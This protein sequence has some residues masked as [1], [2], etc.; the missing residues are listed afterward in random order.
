MCHQ[1]FHI[2]YV[3]FS[4]I[5]LSLTWHYY[6]YL[7]RLVPLKD[8]YTALHVMWACYEDHLDIVKMLVDHGADI[9]ASNKVSSKIRRR[10]KRRGRAHSCH[11][12][13]YSRP[14]HHHFCHLVFSYR[15]SCLPLLSLHYFSTPPYV[16]RVIS[17]FLLR[18]PAPSSSFAGR[19]HSTDACIQEWPPCHRRDV[20][21]SWG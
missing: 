9:E 7:L 4:V 3:P 11:H 15:G 19:I 6:H 5:S 2:P 18:Y 8:G 14:H 17:F 12:T 21:C 20:G 16:L 10:R 1:I 13:P